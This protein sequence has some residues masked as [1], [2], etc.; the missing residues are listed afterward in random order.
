MTGSNQF[1]VA[2]FVK[3][4]LACTL[5]WNLLMAPALAASDTSSVAASKPENAWLKRVPDLIAKG[6]I[7]KALDD[8]MADQQRDNA[9]WHNLMG[10]A[11]RKQQPPDIMR[12]ESHY[13]EA[14]KIKPDHRGALEYYGELLLMKNDLP[15]A[16]EMLKRLS[17]A[18]FFGCEE[19]RDLKKE[20]EAFK[21]R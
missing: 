14:L 11:Y 16:E 7:K 12:S 2:F 19:L 10:F 6:E 20:I 4:L 21:R 1:S 15:G 5:A 13:R 3:R 17:K 8:L 18:C 9:D